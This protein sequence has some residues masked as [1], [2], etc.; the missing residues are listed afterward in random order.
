ME[1]CL[2]FDFVFSE[3]KDRT[4]SS[5]PLNS[6]RP[7]TPPLSLVLDQGIRPSDGLVEA[8]ARDVF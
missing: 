2:N 5:T 3:E 6:D 1:F 7:C 4:K 8:A